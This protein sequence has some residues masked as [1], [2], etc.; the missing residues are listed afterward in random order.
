MLI[1]HIPA[2]YLAGT[3][4]L[5]RLALP[6]RQRRALL[7]ATLITSVAPDLDVIA[8]YTVGGDVHHHAYPPHWPLVWAGV[9]GL[10]LVAGT[11]GRSRFIQLLSLFVG[12]AALLHLSLDSIAGAV[13]WGAPFSTHET[14]LIDVPASRSHWIWSMLL[15]WTFAVELS[16]WA[17]AAWVWRR[18]RRGRQ[19]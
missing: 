18:R 7:A 19:A 1:G 8:F 14:T 5:D 3:A 12:A 13:R 9:V 4:A 16:L 2:G 11:L 15:H 6:L 10:G 17:V